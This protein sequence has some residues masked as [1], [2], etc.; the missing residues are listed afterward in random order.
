MAA[1][2]TL[3]AIGTSHG[4]VLVFDGLQKLKY[5]LGSPLLAGGVKEVNV[6]E[7][8]EKGSVSSLAFNQNNPSDGESILPSRLL[9]GFAKGK[10]H[11]LCFRT[12]CSTK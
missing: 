3:I 7:N 9:V 1:A 11:K 10:R 2:S 8:Q 4:F 5:S 6:A 12:Q